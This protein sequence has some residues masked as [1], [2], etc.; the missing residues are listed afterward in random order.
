[1][2]LGH[3]SVPGECARISP[4]LQR[5]GDK[6][7]VLII[8]V[9]SENPKRFNAL[10]REIESISQRM[11]TLNLR[12]LERDGLVRRTVH[13]TVPPQVE[14]ALTPLGADLVP[15]LFALCEW[16]AHNLDRI[17]AARA[18]FEA[19]SAERA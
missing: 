18:A 14:Y 15:H 6:W 16:S 4:I 2:K 10:R 5:I 11:L 1:M 8:L 17:E 19:D 12:A 3:L 7:A 13:P 9:L